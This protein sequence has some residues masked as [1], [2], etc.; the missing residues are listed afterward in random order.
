MLDSTDPTLPH[1][2]VI[3]TTSA[4]ALPYE[5]YANSP[6]VADDDQDGPITPRGAKNGSMVAANFATF[7]N[8]S[9]NGYDADDDGSVTPR[10]YRSRRNSVAS[11]ISSS[12]STEEPEV[13]SKVMKTGSVPSSQDV[14]E[15]ENTSR[16]IAQNMTQVDLAS[17][18]ST[19][20]PQASVSDGSKRSGNGAIERAKGKIPQASLHQI[21]EG[22][23]NNYRESGSWKQHSSNVSDTSS[24]VTSP[25]TSRESTPGSDTFGAGPEATGPSTDMPAQHNDLENDIFAH[26][27]RH[28]EELDDVK[29]A[30]EGIKYRETLGQFGGTQIDPDAPARNMDDHA[31]AGREQEDGGGTASDS[32]AEVKDFMDKWFGSSPADAPAQ[33]QLGGSG[34]QALNALPTDDDEYYD[35]VDK[36]TF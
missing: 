7:V 8:A 6:A 29:K 19:I 15:V 36:M 2:R 20:A 13:I 33:D 18:A 34:P 22:I 4:Q 1:R 30:K 14:I 21:R 31:S 25:T 28:L 9:D 32:A 3:H 24:V 10:A 11:S 23:R 27:Q 5:S 17:V 35:N 26:A 12:E 16:E